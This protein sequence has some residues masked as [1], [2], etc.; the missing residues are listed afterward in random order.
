MQEQDDKFSLLT[1]QICGRI[2]LFA[3]DFVPESLRI[4]TEWMWS[5]KDERRN[6]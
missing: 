3:K 5:E 2:L 1:N 6:A 4:P